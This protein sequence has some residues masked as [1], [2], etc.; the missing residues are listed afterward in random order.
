MKGETP[1]RHFRCKLEVEKR[2]FQYNTANAIYLNGLNPKK[3]FFYIYLSSLHGCGYAGVVFGR[4]GGLHPEVV[5]SQFLGSLTEKLTIK[6]ILQVRIAVIW[7][8]CHVRHHFLLCPWKEQQ[9]IFA[10]PPFS[11]MTISSWNLKQKVNLSMT[12]LLQVRL[13]M[14]YTY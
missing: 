7:H 2:P 10:L 6:G 5:T 4:Q 12:K 11:A 8:V 14:T 9:H 3:I 13:C 1:Q